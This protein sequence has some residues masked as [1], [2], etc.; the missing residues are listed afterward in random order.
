MAA[1]RRHNTIWASSTPASTATSRTGRKPSRGSRNP[2]AHGYVEADYNLGLLYLDGKGVEQSQVKAAEYFAKAAA[3]GLPDAAMDYGVL[4]FR[5][6]G[7][8]KDEKLGA[9]WMLI[10]AQAW[11]RHRHEPGWP[12][13]MRP[14]AASITDAVA[15]MMWNRLA[16]DGGRPDTWLDEFAGK[17]PAAL[18]KEAEAKAKDFK[19]L[20]VKIRN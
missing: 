19:P 17:Q 14:G 4:V 9:E 2:P 16:S 20:P 11:Q 1:I 5:G 3:R 8:Q 10:A 7:V 18:R 6:E 15:A 12:A 13:F